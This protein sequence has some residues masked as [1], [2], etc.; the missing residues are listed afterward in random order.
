MD[1]INEIAQWVAIVWIFVNLLS[2]S[3]DVNKWGAHVERRIRGP[4]R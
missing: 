3:K 2:F 4:R 1:L